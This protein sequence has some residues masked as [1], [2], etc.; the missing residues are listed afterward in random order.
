MTDHSINIC[1]HLRTKEEIDELFSELKALGQVIDNKLDF[2]IRM[3][4]QK[5]K[6]QQYYEEML[7]EYRSLAKTT[8]SP[9]SSITKPTKAMK[10]KAGKK[11]KKKKKQTSLEKHDEWVKGLTKEEIIAINKERVAKYH[12]K[13]DMSELSPAYRR[14]LYKM[15]MEKSKKNSMKESGQWVSI[16][17]VPFGGMNK[18]H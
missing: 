7:V 6:L 18:K 16:V 3:A 8:D 14:A 4:I 15:E 12:P 1:P 17:S 13:P 2:T 11:V 10:T 9:E 5:V